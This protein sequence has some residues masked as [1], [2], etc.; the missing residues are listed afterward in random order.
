[1]VYIA[2]RV[3]LSLV[4]VF[5][6]SVI[7]FSLL[8]I[9]TGEIARNILGP[10]ASQVQVDQKMVDLGLDQPLV[11]RY[12]DW[13]SSAAH[14]DLGVS[15]FG[16][17]PVV[18]SIRYRLPVTMSLAVGAT[19]VTAA[20]AVAIGLWAATRRGWV[21]QLIQS[22]SVLGFALPGFL[23]AIVLVVVFAIRWRIFPATGYIEPSTSLSGWLKTI[24]LPIV[25]L[26][27]SSIAATA[28]Q[29]RGA[30]IDVLHQD[31]VRT[32][33]SRG[34]GERSILFRYVLK[35]AAPAGLTVLSLQFI[36]LFGGAV[37]VEQIFAIPGIGTYSIQAATRGDLPVVMGVVLVTA[38]I[39]ALVNL[40]IDVLNSW[41]NPKVRVR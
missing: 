6:I 29:V 17:D 31:F 35:N 10:N 16:S 11:D 33:R 20:V 7:T 18:E 8:Y 25:A 9:S 4:L 41:L 5:V 32:L 22:L 19:L 37:I 24:T 1:L 23:V 38:I 15:W 34:I 28:Q 39:V 2:R 36:A 21:D 26:S 12:V 14:G 3:V 27:F 40:T 30:A 13:L